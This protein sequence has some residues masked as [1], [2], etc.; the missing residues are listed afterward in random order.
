VW[1]FCSAPWSSLFYSEDGSSMLLWNIGILIPSYTASHI[2]EGYS[3][4]YAIFYT[5]NAMRTSNLTILFFK[6]CKIV[7][8]PTLHV[9]Q[10][11][12]SCGGLHFRRKNLFLLMGGMVSWHKCIQW[13]TNFYTNIRTIRKRLHPMLKI[14]LCL[15]FRSKI[16]SASRAS[17]DQLKMQGQPN[18]QQ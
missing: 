16:M 6:L 18:S 17:T 2:T 9:E 10:K 15:V 7:T 13:G 14:F 12:G 4:F 11:L 3:V 8:L 1:G 5:I